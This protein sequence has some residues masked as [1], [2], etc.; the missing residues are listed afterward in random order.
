[1]VFRQPLVVPEFQYGGQR[2]EQEVI[3]SVWTFFAV[4]SLSIGLVVMGLGFNGLSF[5]DA[6][7]VGV[8]SLTTTGIPHLPDQSGIW[9]LSHGA[10][11]V[12]TGAMIIGR[13]EVL[14]FLMVLYRSFWRV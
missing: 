9:N 12:A 7:I 11:W 1:M 3:W 10:K 4:F 13:L 14:A 8:A 2:V 5:P 6:L